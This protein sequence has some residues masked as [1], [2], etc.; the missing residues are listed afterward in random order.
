MFGIK[1]NPVDVQLGNCNCY[2]LLDF[3]S[4]IFTEKIYIMVYAD[5]TP[6]KRTNFCVIRTSTFTQQVSLG[7]LFFLYF[8]IE[9]CFCFILLLYE[10]YIW[11]NNLFSIFECEYLASRAKSKAYSCASLNFLVFTLGC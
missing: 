6:G 5:C 11:Q 2:I 1:H 10:P 9:S 8:T 3:V 4:D 7:R